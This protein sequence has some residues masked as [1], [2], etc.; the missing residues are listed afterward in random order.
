M[1]VDR[2]LQLKLISDVQAMDKDMKGV[3]TTFKGMAA[4]AK[5][6]GQA[7]TK[8]I[9]LDGVGALGGM[10]KDSIAG[11]KDGEVAA[12]NLERTF[13]NVGL[14]GAAAA[15]A[16]ERI[17]DQAIG[18]GFD[19]TDA[20]R[21]YD[22]LIKKTKD[23]SRSNQLMALAFDI[24][25]SE[26]VPLSAAVKT[27]MQIYDGSGRA[28]KRYGLDADT[29]M[30]RVRQ[31][32]RIEKGKA[33]EWA[34]DHPMEVLIG[35]IGEGFEHIAGVLVP[36]SEGAARFVE[37]NIV[38]IVVD[39]R[40]ALGG[41]DLAAQMVVLAAGIGLLAVVSYA[42]PLIFLVAAITALGVA[43][44]IAVKE[45]WLGQL[46]DQAVDARERIAA[47]EPTDPL[48]RGLLA[49]DG[50]IKAYAEPFGGFIDNI[51]TSWRGAGEVISGDFSGL[52]DTLSALAQFGMSLMLVPFQ[53]GWGLIQAGFDQLGI[54][55]GKP[56][57]RGIDWIVTTIRNAIDRI[58]SI[59]DSIDIEI[60]RWVLKW[61]DVS[62]PNPLHGTV[63]DIFNTP[64]IRILPGGN[65]K[66]WD[67]VRDL[68]P[69]IRTTR[70]GR[71]DVPRGSHRGGL[72]DVPFD[73]Y[74]ASLHRGEMVVPSDF[75]QRLRGGGMAGTVI[76]INVTGIITN[77]AE[78]GRQVAEALRAYVQRGGTVTVR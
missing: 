31:A 10:L 4:S 28:V 13:R 64:N 29:A 6:W 7:F 67:G 56:V 74:P 47:N 42:H 63:A 46:A 76:N 60:P 75:A 41:G 36:L 53:I 26:Q 12:G 19:D 54:D 73:E 51:A 61:D 17:G 68:F 58:I 20:L 52:M 62:V 37:T 2:V 34:K 11:F 48:Q 14:S 33:K 1:S 3:R 23:V 27:A 38:P 65:F 43:T 9:V 57:K 70:M 8:G 49:L 32:R 5:S 69:D 45:D 50:L 44:A 30:G 66:V 71:M 35:K 25:R 16:I 59:W 39:L 78:V 40:D 72:W 15:D 18:L 21:G 24:A 55:I 22:T 77:P